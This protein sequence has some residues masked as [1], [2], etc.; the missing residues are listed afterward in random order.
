VDL[1]S[2][3]AL[4]AR[5][6]AVVRLL[7]SGEEAGAGEESG[8]LT[9]WRNEGGRLVEVAGAMPP[10]RAQVQDLALW[11]DRGPAALPA[12]WVATGGL[13][14]ERLEGDLLLANAGG[15]YVDE[16]AALRDVLRWQRT[17]RAWPQSSGGLLL[18]RSGVVPGEAAR[19][20]TVAPRPR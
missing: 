5:E 11:G 9:L 7:Q 13:D 18:L 10:V 4:P 12:L 19:F 8:V 1:V 16:S 2:A 14:P 6:T 15:R 20:V 3:R 17:L